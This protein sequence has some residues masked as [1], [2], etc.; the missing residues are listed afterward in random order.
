MGNRIRLALLAAAGFVAC[1]VGG[2]LTLEGERIEDAFSG[3]VTLCGFPA[4]QLVEHGPDGRHFG[5]LR[6]GQTLALEITDETGRIQTVSWRASDHDSPHSPL[7]RV[8]PTGR[9][10]ATLAA[11][12]VGGEGPTDYLYVVA[13][14]GF[15]DGSFRGVALASCDGGGWTGVDHIVVVP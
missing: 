3:E 9:L 7:V 1:D 2:R 11:L 8:T 6:V 4:S 13:D 5:R 12:A 10:T 14:L 15:R